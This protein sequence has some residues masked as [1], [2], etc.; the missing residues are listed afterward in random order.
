MQQILPTL[1]QK[2]LLYGSLLGDASLYPKETIQIEQS[3][4]H[5]EYLFW[6]FQKLKSLTTGKQPS[7]VTRFDKRT[8]R[9]SRSYQFYTRSL[10]RKWR[11]LFY[12]EKKK[13]LPKDFENNLDALALA[14]WFLDDGGRS[15]GIRSG[16]FLTVDSYT[17]DEITRIQETF[18]VNFG[19]QTQSYTSG[20][21]KKGLV[22][23]RLAISGSNYVTF[24][25]LVSPLI[26]EIPSMA[27]KKLPD[28][29]HLL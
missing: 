13:K 26:K 11:F 16:A 4:V 25:T 5:K 8:L 18:L 14:I 20:T 24:Y 7:L 27:K 19:I 3:H 2:F 15:S 10:F 21:S 12:H 6:L 22:Q 28:V 23:K 29:S 17:P 9:E 1:F